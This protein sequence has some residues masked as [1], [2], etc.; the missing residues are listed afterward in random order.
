MRWAAH[1]K[2]A[3]LLPLVAAVRACSSRQEARVGQ[4][5]NVPARRL[6]QPCAAA[7]SAFPY[8]VRSVWLALN[9]L[10]H[11][12]PSLRHGVPRRGYALDAAGGAAGGASACVRCVGQPAGQLAA[13]AGGARNAR[14][15]GG[16]ARFR[17]QRARRFGL[18][19]AA[20]GRHWCATL[21][22]PFSPFWQH[23]ALW[24]PACARVPRTKR[25]LRLVLAGRRVAASS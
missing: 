1:P 21:A 22:A 25:R 24:S 19:G 18:P 12:G 4:R 15:A 9:G 14:R 5:K 7:L 2:M 13:H 10:A 16:A 6:L 11:A 23:H 20:H 8:F 3:Q 17:G